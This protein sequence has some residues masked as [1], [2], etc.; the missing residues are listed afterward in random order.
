MI[1]NVLLLIDNKLT[2]SKIKLSKTSNS[3]VIDYNETTGLHQIGIIKIPIYNNING[4]NYEP[5]FF[6]FEMTIFNNMVISYYTILS[7]YGIDTPN[8]IDF[9]YQ[10]N[11]VITKE[12]NLSL[13][14]F[15]YMLENNMV[16]VLN[17]M[18][19]KAT[20][21]ICMKDTNQFIKNVWDTI[22]IIKLYVIYISI[23]FP[24]TN[25]KKLHT[26][27]NIPN[28]II[29]LYESFCNY[30]YNLNNIDDEIML[31]FNEYYNKDTNRI[32][33]SDEINCNH[34]YYIDVKDFSNTDT[35]ISTIT[36]KKILKVFVNKKKDN[37][38]ELPNKTILFNNYNWYYFYPQIKINKDY[39]LFQTFINTNITKHIIGTLLN[40]NSCSFE[41][42]S[43]KLMDYYY[44]D[45]KYSNLLFLDNMNDIEILKTK[46]YNNDYFKYIVKKYTEENKIFEILEILF[47]QY[48][49]PLKPNR[50]ELDNIF[51]Y[52]LYI[53]IINHKL[54]LDKSKHTYN[55]VLHCS[56]IIHVISI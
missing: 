30:K 32:L 45:N 34:S 1:I 42:Y 49:Y 53:S 52:I 40:I 56:D 25:K 37:I 24:Q 54:I 33:N 31:Q 29:T 47:G 55:D 9:F 48:N 23:R 50:L 41:I 4:I 36:I 17:N 12:Y 39:V 13:A 5:I 43:S 3:I 27:Y 14:R 16:L 51:D 10:I 15:S 26:K 20:F 46:S 22:N 28:R 8:D 21:D 35:A 18:Y 2:S 38:I 6:P 19:D 7:S 11:R 44:N